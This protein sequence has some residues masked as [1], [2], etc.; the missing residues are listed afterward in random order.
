MHDSAQTLKEIVDN[1]LGYFWFIILAMWGG[2][3][4]YI[5]RLKRSKCPFSIIE[6]V[7]EW[8]ISG[9]VGVITAYMCHSLGFD[10]YKT[11]AL[12]GISGHLGGR[13]MYMVEN[14]IKNKYIK[15]KD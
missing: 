13:G 2:T 9:F 11:A 12:V 8:F 6:L 1:S 3:A 14:Y 4:S 5:S 7:G 15:I 10:F